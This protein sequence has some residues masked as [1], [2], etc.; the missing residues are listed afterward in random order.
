[1]FPYSIVIFLVTTRLGA[2][3]FIVF[4]SKVMAPNSE[5][6]YVRGSPVHCKYL[7]SGPRSSYQLR[8]S[9]R[10]YLLAFVW[11]WFYRS[12]AAAAAAAAAAATWQ[13]GR[14]GRA[15]ESGHRHLIFVKQYNQVGP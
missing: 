12:T 3:H 8:T 5:V 6:T 7:E 9:L 15:T 14:F 4:G 10:W 13:V 2:I 11:S 1:M